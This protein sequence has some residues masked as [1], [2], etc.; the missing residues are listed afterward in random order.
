MQYRDIPVSIDKYI[1][2]SICISVNI[3]LLWLNE[4]KS[5]MFKI[6]YYLLEYVEQFVENMFNLNY[7]DLIRNIKLSIYIKGTNKD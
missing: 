7:N 2:T 5:N 4:L 6:I 1:I 3:L